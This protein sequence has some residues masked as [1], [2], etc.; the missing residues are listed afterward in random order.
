M[1]PGGC[2]AKHGF[3]GLLLPWVALSVGRTRRGMSFEVIHPKRGQ[4]SSGA[5]PRLCQRTAEVRRRGERSRVP[6]VIPAAGNFIRLYGCG[7]AIPGSAGLA[8]V[9]ERQL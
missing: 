6:G 2:G 8:P 5:V 3:G 4:L 9:I 7:S 1:V